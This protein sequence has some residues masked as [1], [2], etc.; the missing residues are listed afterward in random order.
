MGNHCCPGCGLDLESQVFIKKA[1]S[2]GKHNRSKNKRIDMQIACY[3]RYKKKYKYWQIA[4]HFGVSTQAVQS[5]F[6]YKRKDKL[7]E[8]EINKPKEKAP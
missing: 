3:L 1:E 6:N 8:T 4:E 7:I 5:I 2:P